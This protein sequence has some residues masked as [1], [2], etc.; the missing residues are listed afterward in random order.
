[1]TVV[2]E[3][4][5]SKLNRLETLSEPVLQEVLDFVSFLEWRLDPSR[6]LN[7]SS[8]ADEEVLETEDNTAS[9]LLGI[10]SSF[11]SELVDEDLKHLPTDGAE[12][13]DR[14]LYQTKS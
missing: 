2:K 14:Y 4:I 12:H 11:A 7:L 9:F 1:M 5:L 6:R 8:N 10:A 13:H 3:L